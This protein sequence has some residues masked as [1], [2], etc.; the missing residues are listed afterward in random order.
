M[1]QPWTKVQRAHS[2]LAD[3]P[4][5]IYNGKSKIALK[6]TLLAEELE[7]RASCSTWNDTVW[8]CRSRSGL[9]AR[10][11]AATW[12]GDLS[13]AI[14]GRLL[15]FHTK[16]QRQADLQQPPISHLELLQI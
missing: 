16:S 15:H 2:G 14:A 9:R 5:H 3:T 7:S 12:C 10:A 11:F 4:Q 8:F 1:V 13:C 6:R